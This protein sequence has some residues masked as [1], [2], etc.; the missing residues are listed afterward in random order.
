MKLRTFVMAA[1]LLAPFS[2]MAQDEPESPWSGK[3]T[4]GYLATSGNTENST[5]NTGFEVGYTSGQWAHLLDAA[6]I[7]SSENEVTTAEAYDLGWK[8]ERNLTD[9]DFLFG[10]LHWRKDKFSGY[11]TQLSETIGYGRRLLDTD[12]HKLNAEIGVGARQSKLQDGTKED[13]TIFRGG[14]DY[15]WLFSETAE[16]RQDLTVE[17]GEEN[18]YFESVTAVSAKL[19]GDLAL[20]ASYTIKHNTDVPALTEKT[21]TYTALSLEYVF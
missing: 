14:M 2:L 7:N 8:S 6:A 5:L 12:V 9:K 15:K 18:T 11:D 10:R 17:G 21:D 19:L 16:F 20:V 1:A 3:A 4:L 13:E